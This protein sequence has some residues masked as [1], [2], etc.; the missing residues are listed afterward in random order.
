MSIFENEE[1]RLLEI[2]RQEA[3][4]LASIERQKELD[5]INETKLGSIML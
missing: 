1:Q 4:E 2:E 3:E 5:E